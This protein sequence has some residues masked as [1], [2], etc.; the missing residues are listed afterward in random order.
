MYK[1]KKTIQPKNEAIFL[2]S[3]SEVGEKR[4]KGQVQMDRK[5]QERENEG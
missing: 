1:K 2:K 4:R 5:D 3:E